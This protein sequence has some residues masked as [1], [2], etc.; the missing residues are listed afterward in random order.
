VAHAD[1]KMLDR[2][3]RKPSANRTLPNGVEQGSDDSGSGSKDP[4]TLIFTGT[5]DFSPNYDG[6]LWFIEHVMPLLV[7]RRPDIRLVVAGQMPIPRLLESVTSN[8]HV[9]GFVPDLRREIQR[10]QLYVAPLISGTG[11]R[12]K[13]IEAIASGTYVIGTPM[14]LECLDDELRDTLLVARTPKEFAKQIDDFLK[15]P[16]SFDDRLRQAM[17]MVREKYRWREK[18]IEL[19]DLCHEALQQNA[20]IG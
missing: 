2:L 6:A 1:K 19:E 7:K 16:K 11:F 3:T 8:I 18:V 4:N 12:N 5:M 17:H 15:N 20:Q 9:L 10:S 13:L 14:A